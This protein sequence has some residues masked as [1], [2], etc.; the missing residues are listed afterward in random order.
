MTSQACLKGISNETTKDKTVHLELDL[1]RGPF[2][3]NQ[4]FQQSTSLISNTLTPLTNGS[5]FATG[6]CSTLLPTTLTRCQRDT[7][8][9]KSNRIAGMTRGQ[10]EQYLLSRQLPTSGTIQQLRERVLLRLEEGTPEQIPK[11][12]TEQL[13][14]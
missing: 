3:D 1:S 13:E 9:G 2:T 6:S 8:D 11:Q 12:S 10:L 4:P 7:K 5:S 14:A